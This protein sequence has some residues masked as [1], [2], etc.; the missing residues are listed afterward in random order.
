MKEAIR[1]SIDN[2]QQ[3]KGG[4]FGAVIVKDG[5]IIAR[6]ANQVTASNDATA[7]A[8]MVA[9]RSACKKLGCFQLSGCELYTNC[10]PCPM[11][12]G[13]IYWAR[14]DR[15]YFGNT[16][17]D[18]KNIGFDDAFIYDELMLN[19]HQRALPMIRFLPNEAAIAFE[20][21]EKNTNKIKY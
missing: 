16:K 6:G 2:V 19:I 18:A 12:I 9:I 1:L 10:E 17:S 8:E 14:L 3:N 13:A 5:K 15:V 21:W 20:L 4:P 11:C 7:H